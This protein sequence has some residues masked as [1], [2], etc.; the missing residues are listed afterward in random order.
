[1]PKLPVTQSQETEAQ[2]DGKSIEKSVMMPPLPTVFITAAGTAERFN[3][4]VKQLLTIN[5][6]PIIRRTI[7]LIRE[8]N[9]DIPIYVITWDDRLKFDDVLIIDTVKTTPS[10]VESILFSRQYW[11]QQNIFLL[12][13]VIFH[14]HTLHQI[15]AYNKTG[16]FGRRSH[17]IKPGSERFALTINHYDFEYMEDLCAI[18]HDIMPCGDGHGGLFCLFVVAHDPRLYPILPVKLE[19]FKVIRPARDWIYYH[20]LFRLLWKPWFFVEVND[21]Y[22]TDID[23]PEE[24]AHFLR[25]IDVPV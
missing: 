25:K 1:M 13:D 19:K 17:V 8:Y 16:M 3:R 10:V 22:T 15:L 11:D 24:Y 14:P 12:G 6:E 2:R 9:K 7:R 21:P 5:G 20:L 23:T 4:D 18:C